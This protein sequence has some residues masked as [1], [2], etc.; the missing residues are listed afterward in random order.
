VGAVGAWSGSL[1]FD[2]MTD[3]GWPCWTSTDSI[4]EIKLGD[5]CKSNVST[6]L[7]CN[8]PQHQYPWPAC[9]DVPVGNGRYK[10]A[11]PLNDFDALPGFDFVPTFFSNGGGDGTGV[12]TCSHDI[13]KV[14]Y[15]VACVS[16]R[17]FRNRLVFH[18]WTKYY[19]CIVD[20]PEHAQT[21]IYDYPCD[22]DTSGDTVLVHMVNKFAEWGVS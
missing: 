12:G 5:L 20:R 10:E 13:T 21:V 8:N 6:Y 18:Q 9:E 3:T 11:S 17:D 16:A 2:V 1:Q 14:E 19:M 22:T 7:G 4:T 15:L